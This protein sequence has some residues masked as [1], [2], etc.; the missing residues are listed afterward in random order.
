MTNETAKVQRYSRAAQKQ[1][2]CKENLIAHDTL[3][4]WKT[5]C[6]KHLTM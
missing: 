3:M 4:A 2:I 1:N 6:K 5:K